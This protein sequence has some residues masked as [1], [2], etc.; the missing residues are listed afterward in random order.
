MRGT[1]QISYSAMLQDIIITKWGKML[2]RYY[3]QLWMYFKCAV[4]ILAAAK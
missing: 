2:D 3:Q 1:A 4:N